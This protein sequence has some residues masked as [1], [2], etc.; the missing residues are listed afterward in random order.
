MFAFAILNVCFVKYID[1]SSLVVCY[2]LFFPT[3]LVSV[4]GRRGK[5]PGVVVVKIKVFMI[6]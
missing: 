1:K 5:G 3:C 2:C 6:L 4:I